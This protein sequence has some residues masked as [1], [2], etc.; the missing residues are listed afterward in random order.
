MA[1]RTA[2]LSWGAGSDAQTAATGLT[3][4]L[5]IGTT[6]TGGQLVPPMSTINGVRMVP[7]FGNRYHTRSAFLINLTP[8]Q[9]YWSVQTVDPG[10][11]GSTFSVTGTFRIWA[12]SIYLPLLSHNYHPVFNNPTEIEPNNTAAE[13]NGGLLAGQAYRGWHNDTSDYFS[14]YMPAG[15]LIQASLT[16]AYQ[17]HVQLQLRSP[18]ISGTTLIAY[19]YQPPFVLTQP[20]TQAGWYY[21]RIFTEAGF[22]NN[23]MYTLTVSYP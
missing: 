6:S 21:V 9:Y 19:M 3:Y 20:I 18:A 2:I 8:G 22:T 13:A 17:D 11:V 10:Y 4:N 12:H 14:V 7:A 16:T 1:G 15:G 5:R 23:S